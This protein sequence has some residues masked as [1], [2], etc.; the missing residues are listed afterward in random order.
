MSNRPTRQ[1]ECLDCQSFHWWTKTDSA[2]TLLT[3]CLVPMITLS[4]IHIV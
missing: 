1:K 3:T 2:A 4:H